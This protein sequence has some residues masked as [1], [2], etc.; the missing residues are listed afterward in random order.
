MKVKLLLLVILAIIRICNAYDGSEA[1]AELERIEALRSSDPTEFNFKIARFEEKADKLNQEELYFLLF[2]KSLKQMKSGQLLP[3]INTLEFIREKSSVPVLKNKSLIVLINIYAIQRE[4]TKGLILI[5][6]LF[7]ISSQVNNDPDLFER[8]IIT[9]AIFYNQVEEFNLGQEYASR[10]LKS[11]NSNRNICISRTLVN[12]SSIYL[13]TLQRTNTLKDTINLCHSLNEHIWEN[14]NNTYLAIYLLEQNKYGEVV[15]ILTRSLNSVEKTNYKILILEYYRLL[16]EAFFQL[17]DYSSSTSFASKVVDNTDSK[18]PLK[19]LVSALNV[20]YKIE[21]IKSNYQKSLLFLEKYSL[22][23]KL[24]L[25]DIKAR[26]MSVQLANHRIVEKNSTIE[27]LNKENKALNLEQSL[28]KEEAQ[29]KSLMIIILILI[30]IFTS[31]WAYR[32]KKTQIKLRHLAEFDSL[33]GI[34]NRRHFAKKC[35]M[36]LIHC[37]ASGQAVSIILFDLDKF[38]SINDS[39]GH[40]TGDW[41]LKNIPKP[42]LDATRKI[43]LFGRMGGEEFAI[44][45]PGCELEQA[46]EIAE[47]IRK[48]LM[49]L[50]TKESGFEFT[51]TASFGVTVSRISG[52]NFDTLMKHSDLALYESKHSGRNKTTVYSMPPTESND[53]IESLK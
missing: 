51:V 49:Q 34:H 8:G 31:L 28:A 40:P 24:Y 17:K 52:Y 33:T 36:S 29:N 11:S 19:P 35:K 4:W 37:K 9:A 6:E 53:E 14:L 5:E 20:L 41:V 47:G 48:G 43:D 22:Y 10:V 26:N 38:K 16:A 2:L 45:L 30:I 44:L 39:Y 27:L 3:A 15:D 1:W 21:K 42:V 25:D 13:N 12:E 7:S 23:E 50:N 46:R 32:T 18:T